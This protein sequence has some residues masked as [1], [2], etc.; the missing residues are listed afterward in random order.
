MGQHLTFNRPSMDYHIEAIILG[1]GVTTPTRGL[2]AGFLALALRSTMGHLIVEVEAISIVHNGPHQ[3][4]VVAVDGTVLSLH[5]PNARKLHLPDLRLQLIHNRL[6]ALNMTTIPNPPLETG[7]T[8]M[9]GP[10]HLG[11]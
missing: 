9:T 2:T 4:L 11:T 7:P 1:I 10:S 5:M 8:K 3:D 6:D